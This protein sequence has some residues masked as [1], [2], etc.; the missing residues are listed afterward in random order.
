MMDVISGVGHPRSDSIVLLVLRMV[1]R[2]IDRA[3]ALYYRSLGITPTL[4]RRGNI[5]CRPYMRD[6]T[7]TALAFFALKYLGSYRRYYTI[8]FENPKN[9]LNGVLIEII[10]LFGYYSNC[11]FT[12][13]NWAH[14]I[15]TL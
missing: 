2:A 10:P 9:L 6:M 12:F 3:P 1:C 8:S 11:M 4:L 5:S 14:V 7:Y 15:P 13:I